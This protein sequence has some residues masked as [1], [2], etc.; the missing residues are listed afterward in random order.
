M[1]LSLLPRLN[2]SSTVLLVSGAA[3]A[4]VGLLRVR[5]R[6][7]SATASRAGLA[8]VGILLAAI[9]ICAAAAL[10]V[11]LAFG[12]Y[13]N[14]TI[15]GFAFIVSPYFLYMAYLVLWQAVFR[16]DAPFASMLRRISAQMAKKL[17]RP[18]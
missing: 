4:S 13:E 8:F 18:L 12:Q 14:A 11:F 10:F 3:L 16:T 9:G 6:R 17:L 7:A 5:P 2:H 15:A 1:I